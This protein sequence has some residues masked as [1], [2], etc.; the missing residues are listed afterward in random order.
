MNVEAFQKERTQRRR[1]GVASS[2]PGF[3]GQM[4]TVI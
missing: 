4:V 1:S 3:S 2:A